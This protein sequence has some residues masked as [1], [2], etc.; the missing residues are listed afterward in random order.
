NGSLSL[1]PYLDGNRTARAPRNSWNASLA[2]L[3][4]TVAGGWKLSASA[5][6]N[7]QDNMAERPINGLRYGARGLLGA[8]LSLERG[9]W[10]VAFWG[11]NLTNKRFIRVAGSRGGVFYPQMPRPIDL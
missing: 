4:L 6:L 3:P 5:S 1:V 11:T 2:L 7:Y 8:Q 9:P 10:Q